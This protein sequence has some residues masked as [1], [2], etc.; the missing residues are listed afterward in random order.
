MVVNNLNMAMESMSREI[1]VGYDYTCNRQDPVDGGQNC[2]S[3]SNL[4]LLKLKMIKVL[5]LNIIV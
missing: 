2:S 1:R 4:F 3:P 5:I